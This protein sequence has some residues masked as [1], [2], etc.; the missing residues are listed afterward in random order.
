MLYYHLGLFMPRVLEL[1]A[2]KG[3]GKGYAFGDDFY[4][5]WLTT[6]RCLLQRCD[7]Y[8]AEMTREIQTGLFGR[9]LNANIPSDPPADY[10]S[11][12]YPAFIDVLLSP[13]AAL[14]FATLRIVLLILLP[15]VAAWSV[16]LWMLAM[17]W[18]PPD[19]TWLAVIV[20]LA[21]CNYPVLEALFAEQPGI[22]V[23]CLLAGSV[24]TLRR[25]HPLLAG[26]LMALTTIK[27][28]MTFLAIV[29]LLLRCLHDRLAG[30]RFIA[31]FFATM[32]LLMGTSVF[33]WPHWIRSWLTVIFGYHRYAT[34]P[35][36]SELLGPV[37][38]PQVGPVL[39]LA[40]LVSATALAWSKR[41]ANT[42]SPDFWLTLS[43]L[44]A[45]TSVTLLP[46]QAVYDHV[47]LLPGILLILH[48]WRTQW[49]QPT[50]AASR[51]FRGMQVIGA[52][53]L[54]WPWVAAFAL[55]AV[56]PW[57]KPEVFYSTPVFALPIRTAG[58]FPFAVLALLVLAL[59]DVPR[60]GLESSPLS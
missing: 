33:L 37:L 10:R 29:Y 9:P 43:L 49:R 42:A 16:W 32:L 54:F 30:V 28:Q 39:I 11:L 47:I 52:V 8:A 25:D 12:A 7:P 44:L 38:G 14:E 2:A 56:R 57:L 53:V 27:P 17:D 41:R 19:P 6:R 40:L 15:L 58:S 60:K 36:A 35:L 48:Q 18:R 21:L 59:R 3:L 34:P 46:G 26:V 20:L 5:I 31:G 13:A 50:P 55:V 4:P 22:L 1:R 51:V 24:L 23:G 45:I